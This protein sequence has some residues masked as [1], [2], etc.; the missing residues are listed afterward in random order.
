MK[1]ISQLTFTRFIASIVIVIYHFGIERQIPVFPFNKVPFLLKIFK[2]GNLG[3][4]YFYVLSG[5][6]MCY[7]YYHDEKDLNK[8]K[9]WI[10]R[11]SRIYPMHIIALFLMFFCFEFIKDRFNIQSLI[12]QITLTQSWSYLYR[13][14]YNWPAWSLSVEVFFY[15]VCPYILLFFKNYSKTAI[16]IFVAFIWSISMIQQIYF[17]FKQFP[18]PFLHLN[19][20]LV[21][22]LAGYYF[23]K[24]ELTFIKNNALIL[25]LSTLIVVIYFA[26]KHELYITNSGLLS[27]IFSLLILS[28]AFINRPIQRFF[29]KNIFILLGE[30]S[31]CIYIIHWPIWL[32]MEKY[33]PIQINNNYF[34]YLYFFTVIAL[35]Y[36][37]YKYI[38]T[39]SRNFLRKKL[40][41]M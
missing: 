20:F 14:S 17:S 40:G 15:L 25:F 34:F 23:R 7:N 30:I 6:I 32:I 3:V 11:F 41:A 38:E 31:Y 26:N 36:L 37:C 18:L 2:G 16:T 22:M 19:S 9:Y 21:G 13:H 8:K 24:Q 4:S 1:P 29:S 5:F 12:F 10:S 28:I 27:P 39:P 33:N 35:S